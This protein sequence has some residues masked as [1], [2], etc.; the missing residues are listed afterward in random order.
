MAPAPN[1]GMPGVEGLTGG[2]GLPR[3]VEDLEVET[4]GVGSYVEHRGVEADDLAVLGELEGLVGQV[5]ADGQ[6]VLLDQ[7]D[8]RL[9][10]RGGVLLGAPCDREGEGDDADSGC[11][12]SE[13]S[14]GPP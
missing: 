13:S 6:G 14:C 11:E 1:V 4:L 9:G 10:G 12:S 7:L 5:R 3:D 2:D 8:A